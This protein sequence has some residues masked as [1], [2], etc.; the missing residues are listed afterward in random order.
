MRAPALRTPLL[1]FLRNLRDLH[2][3]VFISKC[4]SWSSVRCL[5][6]RFCF[7]INGTEY[8][9]TRMVVRLRR[10]EN[11]G[12]GA[13]KSSITLPFPRA[14]LRALRRHR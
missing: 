11:D 13:R 3:A 1:R 6:E 2:S 4:S 5:L 12:I 14:T 7:P 9:Q 8:V 10:E